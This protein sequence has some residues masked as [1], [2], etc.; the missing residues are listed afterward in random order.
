MLTYCQGWFL[1]ALTKGEQAPRGNAKPRNRRALSS[2]PV[3]FVSGCDMHTPCCGFSEKPAENVRPP[4][5]DVTKQVVPGSNQLGYQLYATLREKP[6]NLLIS[7]YGASVS[8]G[9]LLGGTRRWTNPRR[10]TG[11]GRNL[12]RNK[13]S[14]TTSHRIRCDMRWPGS[15]SPVDQLDV[16]AAIFVQTESICWKNFWRCER[17]GGK[18]Q[19]VDFAMQPATA[20]KVINDW[21]ADKSH[22]RIGEIVTPD[23]I[24]QDAQIILANAVYFKGAWQ[25]SFDRSRTQKVPF[26]SRP[27]RLWKST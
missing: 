5:G 14:N 24:T 17:F 2:E 3:P 7:P 19:I 23:D 26:M 4:L 8:L 27:T 9:L 12:R 13:N 15:E 16:A 21:A 10:N 22:N 18:P 20:R 6:G 25:H 11:S 1:R